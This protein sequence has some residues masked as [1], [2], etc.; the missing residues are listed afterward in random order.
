MMADSFFKNAVYLSHVSLQP[1]IKPGDRV[2]DATCGN[3]KDTLFLA[4]LV[5]DE[6]KVFAFDIQQTAIDRTRQLLKKNGMLGRVALIGA[7]HVDLDNYLQGPIK[8]A[9]FNLGYLPGGDHLITTAPA[10]TLTAIDKAM[11]LLIPGGLISIVAYPGHPMG[12]LEMEEVREFLLQIRQQLFEI[13]EVNFINQ[14]NSPPRL[15][16]LYKKMEDRD[17]C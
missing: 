16:L 5:G 7:D 10:S 2:L 17:E 6:G 9:M 12:S 1:I 15:F 13:L 14:N 3:G 8:A 11:R 4:G